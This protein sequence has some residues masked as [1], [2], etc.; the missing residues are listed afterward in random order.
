MT[1]GI[2]AAR[3]ELRASRLPAIG[4]WPARSARLAEDRFAGCG[5]TVL[6]AILSGAS[7][8]DAARKCGVGVRTVER[9][10]EHGRREPAGRYGP[11]AQAVDARRAARTL[12]AHDVLAAMDEDELALV[13]SET[14]RAGN[15]AAMKLRFEM[16][17]AAPREASEAPALS[18]AD[19]VLAEMDE[20]AARR[21]RGRG[22]G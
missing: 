2:A 19:A 16:L 14:A 1:E 21:R 8:A 10:L 3:A 17:R 7:T 15:V 18:E 5:G 20:L 4:E 6:E 12:P 9:W 11:F 13:V 22:G